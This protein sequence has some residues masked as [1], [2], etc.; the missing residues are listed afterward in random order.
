MTIANG[1]KRRAL[2]ISVGIPAYSRCPELDE[3][4]RSIYCQT[5]LPREITVCEDSSPDRDTIRSIVRDWERRF[6]AA[7]CSV[8]YHE[9]AENLGYDGNFRKVVA[10]SHFPWVIVMGNDDLMLE[11]CI[12]TVEQYLGQHPEIRMVSR[13][14]LRFDEDIGQPLGVSRISREDRN[15]KSTNSSSSM[16]FRT[17]GFVSGLVINRS[18]A[19]SRATKM[20]DGTLYY[21]IYLA[22]VAFCQSGIGYIANP[23]VAGRAG[24]APLFG[25]A[26]SEKQVHVPGSYSPKGRA[27]MW[28]S[29]MRIA[30]DTGQEFEVDLETDIKKELQVRQSFHIFEMYAG[31]DPAVLSSMR[32]EL[33][34]LGLFNHPIPRFL[35]VLNYILGYRARFFYSFVRKMVQHE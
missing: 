15:F 14:F 3:L 16:I 6:E 18:W 27:R 8:N 20:Y 17:C 19:E 34:G 28:A 35:Y 13:S 21:Q 9:N 22:S 24:N 7:G 11:S 2:E 26:A 10:V 5:V 33:K 32:E 4:L 29:V 1:I 30:R 31:K 23:T 25:S 12:E